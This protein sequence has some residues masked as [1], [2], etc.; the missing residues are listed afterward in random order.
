MFDVQV[1]RIHQY[2]RQ[3]LN[4]LSIIHRADCI[5]NMSP[6]EKTKVVPRVCI[7]GGKAAPGYE[8]AKKIIKLVTTVGEKINNDKDIGNLLKVVC[9]FWFFQLDNV[10]SN[11][12][13]ATKI[14]CPITRFL[15][16]TTMFHWQN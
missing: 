10:Y 5:K 14:C 12:N 6:A 16:P 11:V 9:H 8:I 3:L 13:S 7:I 2:K 15:S 1:K 4:V